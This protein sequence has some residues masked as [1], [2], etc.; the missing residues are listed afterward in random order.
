MILLAVLAVLVA[1]TLVHQI[2]QP[3]NY[4]YDAER[5][6]ADDKT[7]RHSAPEA[8]ERGILSASPAPCPSLTATRDRSKNHS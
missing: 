5:Y 4:G 7:Q 2:S 1:R 6:E 3:A 8:E